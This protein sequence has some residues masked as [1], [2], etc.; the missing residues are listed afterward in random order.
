MHTLNLIPVLIPRLLLWIAEHQSSKSKVGNRSDERGKQQSTEQVQR[1]FAKREVE[2]K[3][4]R[5]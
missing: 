1:T 3:N 2:I 5:R 4:G